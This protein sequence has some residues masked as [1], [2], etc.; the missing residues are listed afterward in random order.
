M[1]CNKTQE[2]DPPVTPTE[3]A[4][5]ITVKQNGS[6]TIQMKHYFKSDNFTFSPD[7]FI[8]KAH[9]TIQVGE[10]KYYVSHITLIHANGSLWDAGNFNLINA[11]NTEDITISGI[12]P[13]NYTGMTFL[14]GVDSMN[15]HTLNH[16]EPAL[17]PSH[18]MSWSWSTGYIFMRVKGTYGVAK[19][20]FSFD[21]GGDQHLIK[22]PFD[23]TAYKYAKDS[24][25]M[26]IKTDL[27][28]FF[29]NP[30][31]YDLKTQ[32]NDIHTPIEPEI[33]LFTANM[34]NGMFTLQSLE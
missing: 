24:Y 27:N 4:P 30:N 25:R 16:N 3:I 17:D 22:L 26:G 6:L 28:E 19:K 1:G 20:G 12:P 23:F 11:Q 14:L 29:E 10:W 34:A 15:N 33:A 7:S 2:D 31:T 8:T 13:G 18:G 5:G 32:L 21:L 9:D